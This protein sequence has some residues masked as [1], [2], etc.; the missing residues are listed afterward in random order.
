[1]GALAAPR[2]RREPRDG[3][4]PREGSDQAQTGHRSIDTRNRRGPGGKV[5]KPRLL[6]IG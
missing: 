1:V 2:I 6:N 5:D 4:G 3:A